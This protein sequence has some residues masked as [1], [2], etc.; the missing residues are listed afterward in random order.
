MPNDD[1]SKFA[2]V[3]SQI[4]LN[5]KNKKQKAD[6]LINIYF[7]ILNIKV[8]DSFVDGDVIGIELICHSPPTS[9]IFVPILFESFQIELF[10]P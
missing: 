9:K 2:Y 7:A 6:C 3:L 5:F 4:S 10:V 8:I 1:F